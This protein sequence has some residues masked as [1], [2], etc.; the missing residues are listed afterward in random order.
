MTIP[1]SPNPF[2]GVWHRRFIQ[3]DRGAPETNQQVLWIQAESSFADIRSISFNGPLTAERYQ[4][5]AW[6]QRFDTDLL[7]FTGHFTWV[8]LDSS[9]GTC[10]WHHAIAITP[11]YRPDTS[12]YEW[13]GDNQFLE[14]GICADDQGQPRS[15]IEHWYRVKPGPVRV[16]HWNRDSYHGRA[17]V[18]GN[19][20]A[21][22][23]KQPEQPSVP[24]SEN[25]CFRGF[26][27]SAWQKISNHWRLKFGS[28]TYL[29]EHPRWSPQDLTEGRA[30][31]GWQ[32]Y[33]D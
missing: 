4:A 13:I 9:H 12:T 25:P 29:E 5:M 8:P 21:I 31:G 22:I 18:A 27:A 30:E 14:Q 15:F 3:F 28:H 17:F 1:S 7:G 2:T 26:S 11:R 16:W 24:S 33:Q 10:T 20:A 32:I 6:R 19:W 23:Y